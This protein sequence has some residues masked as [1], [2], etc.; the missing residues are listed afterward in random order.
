MILFVVSFAGYIGYVFYDTSN[1]DFSDCERILDSWAMFESIQLAAHKECMEQ[2]YEERTTFWN[3]Y[4]GPIIL[5][6]IVTPMM[7]HISYMAYKD[8]KKNLKENDSRSI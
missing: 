7:I 8:Y 3:M 2:S 6:G 5:T 4:G 1:K